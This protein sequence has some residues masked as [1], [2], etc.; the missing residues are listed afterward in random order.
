MLNILSHLIL[1]TIL[2]GGYSDFPFTD[3][4]IDKDNLVDLHV[5]EEILKEWYKNYYSEA[6][7][8]FWLYIESTAD[9]TE[10]LPDYLK[11]HGYKFARVNDFTVEATKGE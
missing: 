2:Y 8:R 3:E 9:D 4:E 5:D 7:F 1:T 10:N 11:K 6:S